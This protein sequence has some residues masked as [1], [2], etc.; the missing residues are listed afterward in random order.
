LARF[1]NIAKRLADL[2]RRNMYRRRRVLDSPQGREVIVEGRRLLNF[3]SNDYL[4]LAADDR[5]RD[6][7][8]QAIA[9]W[10][11]GAGAS[12]LVCGH[13]RAHHEL[14]QALAG[15]T[16]RPRAL[17]F[18]SGYAANMGTVA[19]LV[20]AGDIVLEDRLN[21]ASLLDGGWI[22]RAEFAWYRH[23]DTADLAAQLAARRDAG[24]HRLIVSDG[25]FSMDGD[26]CPLDEIVRLAREHGAWIMVD[27][28]HGMG[29][30]GRE[31]CGLVDPMRY[32]L[33]DV[34]VL[35]GTLGKAFGTAG[36]FVAGSEDLIEL[37]IQR[38]RT[39]I[40]TTALPAAVATATL[41]S[42]AIARA[43]Q[44]R[45]QRLRELILRFRRGASELGLR[46]L[47]SATPIQP[48]VV[49]DPGLA[50]RMSQALE[51][52]GMLVTAIRPPTV[53]VSTS[54]LRV[55]LTAAHDD[56]DVD[57]LLEAFDA[58]RSIAAGSR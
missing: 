53:P 46:L 41:A 7:F 19:A 31:G 11:V 33:E 54:R 39:Y 23:A 44:W 13:T 38:A 57:R 47:D 55:T 42:L 8:R 40:Y 12:H 49:G 9:Q 6:A 43:E 37:L 2:R 45:R 25:T 36:A 35:M 15:F 30:H 3:C 14:E 58:T 56:A 26:L 21:H 28:A 16:G 48:V 50:V 1:R 52:R 29:V 51:E 34:P 17:L 32:S 4:G 18:S 22:S 20:G 10:G 5:V 24:G 27:D